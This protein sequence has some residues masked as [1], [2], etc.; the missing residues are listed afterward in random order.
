MRL[1]DEGHRGRDT[2]RIKMYHEADQ[3]DPARNSPRAQ[4]EYSVRLLGFRS[5]RNPPPTSLSHA[6]LCPSLNP[7]NSSFLI[8]KL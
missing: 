6:F 8:K 2:G 3:P 5:S 1:M 4:L 7:L